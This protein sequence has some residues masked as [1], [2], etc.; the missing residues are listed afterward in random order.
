MS[1]LNPSLKP[2]ISD[3]GLYQG[4]MILSPSEIEQ[5][6]NGTFMFSSLGDL[7]KMWPNAVV[8]Y[9]ID[10]SL[11]KFIYSFFAAKKLQN[12]DT[13]HY[14]LKCFFIQLFCF[15]ELKLKIKF[16]VLICLG[17]ERKAKSGI[18]SAIADYHKY[19]CLRFKQRTNER[20]YIR[21]WRGS[22]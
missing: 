15:I 10:S 1:Y 3:E 2:M 8:P 14:T 9:V 13:N 16:F 21:F 6:Q 18:E 20:E 7:S 22:G 11:S 12:E 4:D 17:N 5:V 19:T